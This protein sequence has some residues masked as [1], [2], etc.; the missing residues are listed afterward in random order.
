MKHRGRAVWMGL[1]IVQWEWMALKVWGL[2]MQ[3]MM[4]N[5]TP[6]LRAMCDSEPCSNP[7]FHMLNIS[8]S[9]I[10]H[11]FP[12]DGG[13]RYLWNAGTHLTTQCCTSQDCNIIQYVI[14]FLPDEMNSYEMQNALQPDILYTCW[15]FFCV[16]SLIIT[17][18]QE[19][20]MLEQGTTGIWRI[21][22]VSLL[23]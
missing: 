9:S 19:L 6:P 16:R 21:F 20:A 18:T 13:S 4:Y 5:S 8:F 7:P 1:W 23:S 17:W 10:Q 22:G 14:I 12:E 2:H 11:F 3:Y 15:V